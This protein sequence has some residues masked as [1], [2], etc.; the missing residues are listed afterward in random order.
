M[1]RWSLMGPCPVGAGCQRSAAECEV[2]LAHR[3]RAAASHRAQRFFRDV[4]RVSSLRPGKHLETAVGPVSD[5]LWSMGRY[6]ATCSWAFV[7]SPASR[8]SGL[9]FCR[10]GTRYTLNFGSQ[11]P[12]GGRNRVQEF[13]HLVFQS[14]CLVGQVPRGIQ[15]ILS[16]LRRVSDGVGEFLHVARY[17]GRAFGRHLDIL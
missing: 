6:T 9:S 3:R 15:D 14:V 17:G 5:G 2:I 13:F 8:A 11:L 12:S 10:S 4:F 1:G 7:F 16:G